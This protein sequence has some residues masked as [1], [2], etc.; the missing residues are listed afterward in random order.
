M[1]DPVYTYI[2]TIKN[3]INISKHTNNITT[4][5]TGI[6][7]IPY[8]DWDKHYIG[9]TQRNLAKR[10][11]EHKWSIELN[12]DQNA[13]FSHMLDLKYTFNFFQDTF[14]EPIHCKKN[15]DSKNLLS[16]PKLNTLKTNLVSSRFHPFQQT[17]F[18]MKKYQNTKLIKMF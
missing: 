13:L 9:E 3:P 18:Y 5:H 17:L 11:Y 12:D 8:K 14:I 1:P 15:P 6:Y 2:L 7:S 16:F 10:M 4:F